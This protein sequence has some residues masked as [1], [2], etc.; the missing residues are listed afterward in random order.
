MDLGVIKQIRSVERIYISN[1]EAQ[2][3]LDMSDDQL[4]HLREQAKLPYRKLG[5]HILYRVADII[6]LVEKNRKL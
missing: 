3:Y 5:K 6:R 1:R 4:R 2:I